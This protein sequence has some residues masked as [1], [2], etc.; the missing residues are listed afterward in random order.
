[1]RF[2]TLIFF[3]MLLTLSCFRI[4]FRFL[5]RYLQ[6]QKLR[7]VIYT[8]DSDRLRGVINSAESSLAVSLTPWN[9]TL[10]YHWPRGVIFHG[11]ND[12]RTQKKNYDFFQRFF[13]A[14][15]RQFHK[16]FDIVFHA[17]NS[18]RPLIHCLNHFN[19]EA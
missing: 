12:T 15:K 5:R 19:E 14:L 4:L 17:K 2:F 13:S 6:M 11:V 18:F 10:R 8:A 9:H 3:I 16:I 1:M 7:S